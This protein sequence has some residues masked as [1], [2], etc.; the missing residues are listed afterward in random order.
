[1]INSVDAMHKLLDLRTYDVAVAL[2]LALQYQVECDIDDEIQRLM[3][4]EDLTPEEKQFIAST[5]HIMSGNVF[6]STVM[7]R[8]G[9]EKSKLDGVP[10]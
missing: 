9:G 1:M 2:T 3:V 6:V 5:I 10:G 7:S 4:E 8:Y